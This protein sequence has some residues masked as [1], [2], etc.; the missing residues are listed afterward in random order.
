M[1]TGLSQEGKKL[2]LEEKIAEALNKRVK[3]S[4]KINQTV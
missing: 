2:N 3:D 4:L 1:W